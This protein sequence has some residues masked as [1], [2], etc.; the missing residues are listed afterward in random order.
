VFGV[1]DADVFHCSVLLPWE[2]Q[3]AQDDRVS[4]K[5][6]MR[7]LHSRA[8]RLALQMNTIS[9]SLLWWGGAVLGHL[10]PRLTNFFDEGVV[11]CGGESL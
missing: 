9:L 4:T 2:K 3:R 5:H 10:Y 7:H 1:G 6:K 8:M 11:I